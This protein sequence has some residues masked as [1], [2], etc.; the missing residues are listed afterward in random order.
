MRFSAQT[1]TGPCQA[2]DWRAIDEWQTQSVFKTL[3]TTNQQ[4]AIFVVKKP[5]ASVTETNADRCCL[6]R[7]VA[8]GLVRR[9]DPSRLGGDDLRQRRLEGRREALMRLVAKRRSDAILFSEALV[10]D[11]AVVYAKACELGVEAIVS[12]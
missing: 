3:D 10:E 7:L 2:A 8:R 12:K 6:P 4:R 1:A 11:S 9:L 5:S